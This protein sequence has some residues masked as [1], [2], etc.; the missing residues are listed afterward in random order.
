M[1]FYETAKAYDDEKEDHINPFLEQ[2]NTM[3]KQN[4]KIECTVDRPSIVPVEEIS[5]NP[6]QLKQVEQFYNALNS[7]DLKR[8]GDLLHVI[9]NRDMRSEVLTAIAARVQRNNHNTRVSWTSGIQKNGEPDLTL[10][11]RNT[12]VEGDR[13]GPITV[14]TEVVLRSNGHYDS[15]STSRRLD[16]KFWARF[17][18]CFNRR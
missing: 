14:V 16:T 17:D 15:L 7:L 1:E 8:L 4:V 3:S 9:A 13:F 2:I 18:R 11:L 10:Y 6:S 5:L 12:S